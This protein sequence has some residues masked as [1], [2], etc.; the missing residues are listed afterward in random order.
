MSIS[1]LIGKGAGALSGLFKAHESN[2]VRA[3]NGR[4]FLRFSLYDD[5]GKIR[6][7]G[8]DGAYRGPEDVPHASIL[9]VSGYLRYFLDRPIAEIVRAQILPSPEDRVLQ[10]RLYR[11]L[12]GIS[13]PALRQFAEAVLMTPEIADSFYRV[14]ASS[15]HH[16]SYPGGL[17]DHSLE[18]AEHL[19]GSPGFAAAILDIGVVAALLHDIGKIRT[20]D[21]CGKLTKVGRLVE[22]DKLTLEILAHPLT[23]LERR[24]SE[25]ANF[26]RSLWGWLASGPNR[27]APNHAIAE[28]VLQADHVSAHRGAEELA[29]AGAP[30][31]WRHAE[32]KGRRY[33][34]P[35]LGAPR[36]AGD[37]EREDQ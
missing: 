15:R 23:E 8:W 36:D 33:Y 4:R 29:F 35:T 25:M 11:I 9:Q 1:E 30:G 16:H 21:A 13:T 12:T 22:H 7:H 32:Y 28:V 3:S 26:L 37:V 27:R 19:K 5:T 2:W 34:R 20:H 14:P 24:D 18:C 10:D 31:Y 17:L 6:A